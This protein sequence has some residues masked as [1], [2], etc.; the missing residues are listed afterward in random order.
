MFFSSEFFTTT[1]ERSRRF[2]VDRVDPAELRAIAETIGTRF[3]QESVLTFDNLPAGDPAV[4]AIELEVPGVT[5]D[6]LRAGPARGPGGG[7]PAVRRLRDARRAPDPDRRPR[8]RR[9][10]PRVRPASSAATSSRAVTRRGDREFVEAPAPP[11]F[12]LRHHRLFVS[13]GAADEK[14]DLRVGAGALTV[15]LDGDGT[16]DYATRRRAVERVVVDGGGGQDRLT[17]TAARAGQDFD[18]SAAHGRV[19]ADGG[20]RVVLDRVERLD[21]AAPGG[22]GRVNVGDLSFTTLQELHGA[23]GQTRL[24]GTPERDFVDLSTFAGGPVSV[25]GLPVFVQIDDAGA[26]RRAAAGRPAAATTS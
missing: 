2:D 3:H 1:F 22:P 14:I 6:A 10:R 15:D 20:L 19:R 7:E 26:G 21:L 4:D 16:V 18:V 12:E 23:F 9:V 13:G 5:A 25:I 24:T 17:F 8:R 11:P